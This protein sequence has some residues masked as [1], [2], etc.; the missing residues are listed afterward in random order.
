M[1]EQPQPMPP[2]W[3]DAILRA[4]LAP[5]DRDSVSGDLLEEYRQNVLRGRGR[6]RAW[7]WY[8]GQV[9]GF[10]WRAAG[11][12]SVLLA[13]SIV[14][15]DMLDWWLSPTDDFYARSIVSTGVAVALFTSAGLLSAW[16]SRSVM[17]GALG[18]VMMG[19]IAAA[20]INLVSLAQLAI[21]HDPHTLKM[22][23]ASG[24]LGEV[25][26]LPVM[27]IVPGTICATVGGVAGKGLAWLGHSRPAE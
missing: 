21:W 6:L 17:A 10:V 12:W 20:I 2:R 27:I 11:L 24:G 23:E 4:I 19:A 16:R 26:I 5:C 25:F 18:G 1:T 14:G 7:A 22:I 3:A 8:L 13:A 15:R 9:A